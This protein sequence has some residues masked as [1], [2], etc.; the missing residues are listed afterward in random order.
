MDILRKYQD[1]IALSHI[2]IVGI[3][4]ATSC[5]VLNINKCHPPVQQIIRLKRSK[6]LK[7]E[8]KKFKGNLCIYEAFYVSWVMNIML[9]P[10]PNGK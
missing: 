7:E 6:A 4:L 3:D 1:V 5:H 8:V 10:K 2:A 9:V